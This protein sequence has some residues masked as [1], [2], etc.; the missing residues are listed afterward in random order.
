MAHPDLAEPADVTVA[1]TPAG[2]RRLLGALP[3]VLSVLLILVA[4]LWIQTPETEIARY[5]VHLLL[6]VLMP[7]LLLHRSLRGRPTNLVADLALGAATGT[8]V[9]LLGLAIFVS[10]GIPQLLWLWPVAI[11]ATYAAVPRLRRHWAFGGYEREGR[12]GIWLLAATYTTYALSQLGQYANEKLPPAANDYYIDVYW[13]MANAGELTRRFP[14]EVPSVS[15][16]TLRYHWFA[17]ADM[18]AAHLTTG[19]DLAVLVLRLWPLAMTAIVAGL[20]YALCRRL[21]GASWPGALAV[22]MVVMPALFMP[23]GWFNTINPVSVLQGS[24]SQTYGVIAT[25]LATHVLVDLLKGQ[26]RRGGW[27]VLVLAVFMGPGAKPSVIPILA[28]ALGTVMLLEVVLRRSARRLGPHLI[29]LVLMG[30]AGVALI[31]LVA[32]AQAASGIKLFGFLAKT[33]VW[34]DFVPY[35][36]LPATG[37]LVISSILTPGAPLLAA[38][39]VAGLLL[40][41]AWAGLALLLPVRPREVDPVLVFLVA[42]FAAA[43]VLTLVIDHAGLSQIYFERTGTPL[44]AA[45]AVW[46]VHSAWRA[47]VARVGTRRALVVVAGAAAFGLVVHVVAGLVDVGDKP[48]VSEFP[49][50]VIAPQ[51]AILA[52]AVLGWLAWRLLRGRVGGLGLGGLAAAAATLALFLPQGT[53]DSVR[54]GIR[55]A[56]HPAPLPRTAITTAETQ[57]ALWVRDHTPSDAILATNTHC[58]YQSP[59]RFCESRSYWVTALTDRRAVVESWAYTEENLNMIG[60]FKRGFPLFPFD[61]PARLA[62]N[63]AAITKPTAAILAELKAKYGATWIFADTRSSTVS[64]A[65]GTL[66]T[67]RLRSGPVWVYE[68]R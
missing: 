59:Y 1:V 49:W 14:P 11:M 38:G 33:F 5:A 54:Y 10:T 46:G 31:P 45:A 32:Q 4:L 29:A 23:W 62:L 51:L 35:T 40:Q 55:G 18:A 56:F 60:K 3:A 47:G 24:P 42:G 63:D 22:L 30:V 67:L 12:G 66:A 13:H 17:N 7:G 68:L 21:T 43:M 57:A 61:D 19:S 8:T 50:R 52:G 65:L 48:P 16:R 15:G 2:P 27:V 28:A 25:L 6:G 9:M 53:M 20:L 37:R 64:P 36:A 44:A 26:M 41:V 58:K 39:L 34:T